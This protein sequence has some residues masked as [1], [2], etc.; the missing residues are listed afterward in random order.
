MGRGLGSGNASNGQEREQDLGER[1]GPWPDLQPRRASSPLDDWIKVETVV[2][3]NAEAVN[4]M[5]AAWESG[6]GDAQSKNAQNYVF[7]VFRFIPRCPSRAQ[8]L[9]SK[10]SN[11]DRDEALRSSL[12][13][14]Q[15][16]LRIL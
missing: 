11:D 8:A 4:E 6:G 12:E 10:L 5:W 1:A 16:L 15:H 7:P 14:L 3:T 13:L 9:G 2:G